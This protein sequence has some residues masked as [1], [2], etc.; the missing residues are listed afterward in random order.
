LGLLYRNHDIVS[1]GPDHLAKVGLVSISF[2][3]G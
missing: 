1:V 2:L 3:L